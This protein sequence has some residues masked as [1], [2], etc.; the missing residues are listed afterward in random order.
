MADNIAQLRNALAT[1]SGSTFGPDYL[2][3]DDMLPRL[4]QAGYAYAEAT[5]E[6]NE[7]LFKCEQLLGVGQRSEAIRQA[8]IDPDLLKRFA[9]LDI[10]VR[11][12]WTEFAGRN[13]L[14]A[15]AALNRTAATT[16]NQ[17][18]AAEE[19][20]K[21]NLQQFRTLSLSRA[22]LPQRLTVLRLLVQTEPANVAWIDD[23]NRFEVAR[24]DEIRSMAARVRQNDD[25]ALA[26]ELAKEVQAPAWVTKPPLDLIDVVLRAHQDVLRRD[27]QRGLRVLEG[28]MTDA[29]RG[30]DDVPGDDEEADN[31]RAAFLADAKAVRKDVRNVM[32]QF[33]L[34]D[35]DPLL[36]PF[37]D[38]FQWIKTQEDDEAHGRKF[39]KAVRALFQAIR[40]NH[41]WWYVAQCYRQV[42]AFNRPI[43][44]EALDAY[45]TAKRK[46]G[47]FKQAII[48]GAVALAIVAVA[49][50]FIVRKP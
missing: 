7:R 19:R 50:V 49:V 12:A 20:V 32:D 43:P 29:V 38:V 24:F 13:G 21:D 4:K 22:P 48:I 10:P 41:D 18:F 27:L 6:V 33:E 39:Q 15:P 17:A 37:R 11:A 23:L 14:P 35:A 16:L 40:D 28:R 2:P 8:V 25:L 36:D 46:R 5:R 3:T 26:T 1:I 31:A 47:I 44:Q 34:A 30:W 42:C 9:E 45:N